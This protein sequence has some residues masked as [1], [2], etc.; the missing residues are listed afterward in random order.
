MESI[1]T[2]IN[3]ATFSVLVEGVE[4]R[5]LIEEQECAQVAEFEGNR[6]VPHGE[7]ANIRLKQRLS[8]EMV[9]LIIKQRDSVGKLKISLRSCRLII[10]AEI[11]GEQTESVKLA[12]GN[13]Y[14]VE[15]GNESK[16]KRRLKL[17]V[18]KLLL[19]GK[20]ILADLEKMDT[21]VDS[22][23]AVS[24]E[25]KFGIWYEKV[26][27]TLQ[28]TPFTQLWDETKVGAHY[29]KTARKA[30]YV[31]VCRSGL[32]RLE[33]IKQLVLDTGGSQTE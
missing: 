30:D 1:I 19:D 2:L 7:S 15:T 26:T 33:Y 28:G 14:G 22:A 5:F 6:R 9:E 3:A 24:A 11:P 27:G 31:E 32:D 20:E 25:L 8:P 21:R 18:G 10:R 13:E 16:E 23:K 12:A 4:G 29:Y 17:E